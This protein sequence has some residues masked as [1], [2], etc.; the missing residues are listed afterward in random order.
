MFS[1]GR[2]HL[3]STH[4]KVNCNLES[5]EVSLM[6]F[7]LLEGILKE[8]LARSIYA[9]EL[10]LC[11]LTG[12]NTLLKVCSLNFFVFEVGVEFEGS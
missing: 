10:V 2:G 3:E 6:N 4:D 7:L 8:I 5:F 9:F 12:Q 11:S 1:F